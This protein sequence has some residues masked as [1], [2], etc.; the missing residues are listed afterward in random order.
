MRSVETFDLCVDFLL[1]PNGMS[2]ER[3]TQQTAAPNKGEEVAFV[4]SCAVRVL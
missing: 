2:W 3:G 4:F 1:G